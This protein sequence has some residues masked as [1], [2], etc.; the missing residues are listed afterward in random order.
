MDKWGPTWIGSSCLMAHRIIISNLGNHWNTYNTTVSTEDS[1]CMF[2]LLTSCILYC[3]RWRNKIIWKNSKQMQCSIYHVTY[4][5]HKEKSL[6][7]PDGETWVKFLFI[8]IITVIYVKSSDSHTIS[9]VLL[10]TT[11][12]LVTN[13]I[14]I[15]GTHTD[16]FG[17]I[18]RT[19]KVI[20]PHT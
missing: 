6:Y 13:C 16:T 3:H 15:K 4:V 7:P 11:A 9:L 19:A 10:S 18:Q 2:I 5:I 17:S 20:R 1:N 14:K 12:T 8:F